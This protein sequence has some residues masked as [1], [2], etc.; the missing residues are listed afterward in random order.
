MAAR[1]RLPIGRRLSERKRAECRH[2]LGFVARS[3]KRKAGDED[4]G[5]TESAD[6]TDADDGDVTDDT[7]DTGISDV[8]DT[9]ADADTVSDD[10]CL[11][12]RAG[13]S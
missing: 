6:D 1:E 3:K 4:S 8:G 9:G 12:D 5:S 13:E 7:G 10:G 2:L 11:N